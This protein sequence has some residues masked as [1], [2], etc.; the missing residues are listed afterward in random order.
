MSEFF[1][2][3]EIRPFPSQPTDELPL[4][5][6]KKESARAP[7][8]STPT[9]PPLPPY[10]ACAA[11]GT[12]AATRAAEGGRECDGGQRVT[13]SAFASPLFFS[14]LLPSFQFVGSA[15]PAHVTHRELG[16]VCAGGSVHRDAYPRPRAT[17]ARTRRQKHAPVT[18]PSSTDL[19]PLSSSLPLC[20][21]QEPWTGEGLLREEPHRRDG[22]VLRPV[23][24]A[25]AAAA[26]SPFF[27]SSPQARYEPAHPPLPIL[28]HSILLSPQN[29]NWNIFPSPIHTLLLA[30]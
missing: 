21:L 22:L 19:H 7:I 28:S 13:A 29:E 23:V 25:A 3:P 1:F 9:P 20:L 5:W 11:R 6:P 15:H 24:R 27:S 2:H 26:V 10:R 30:S 4:G 14:F 8:Q 18:K 12:V 17:R 16:G